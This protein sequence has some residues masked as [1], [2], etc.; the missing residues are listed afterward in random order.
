M[1][2]CTIQKCN[3]LKK[4]LAKKDKVQWY[5]NQRLH[6]SEC[7]KILSIFS[8]ATQID[9][10]RYLHFLI[11]HDNSF[12]YSS[13]Q[14][15]Q[16]PRFHESMQLSKWRDSIYCNNFDV[17]YKWNFLLFFS[18]TARK[19]FESSIVSS[20]ISIIKIVLLYFGLSTS[21]NVCNYVAFVT[22]LFI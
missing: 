1:L 14:T 22:C 2:F 19:L 3:I 10:C 18:A 6:L 16:S 9:R 21:W 11:S 7:N 12:R 4:M 17:K 13:L 8:T 20:A 5:S 15:S